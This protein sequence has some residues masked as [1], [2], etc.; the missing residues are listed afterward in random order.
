MAEINDDKLYLALRT[1][2][3]TNKIL[4]RHQRV[5]LVKVH[6]NK[7]RIE[8]LEAI[9]KGE[10]DKFLNTVIDHNRKT[11]MRYDIEQK[12]L[13]DDNNYNEE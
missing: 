8:V 12:E 2:K 13:D 5:D 3:E 7:M 6:E 4:I 11:Q 10:F 9:L 1:I